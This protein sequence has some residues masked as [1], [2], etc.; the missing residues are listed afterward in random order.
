MAGSFKQLHLQIAGYVATVATASELPD[1]SGDSGHVGAVRWIEDTKRLVFWDG[2]AW[3]EQT[4]SNLVADNLTVNNIAYIN[5]NIVEVGDN[6]IL[7]NNDVTGAPSENSGLIVERGTSPDA[8]LQW[9]EATDTWQ[10]GLDG[11]PLYDFAPPDFSNVVAP[12]FLFTRNGAVAASTWLL[13]GDVPSNQASIH[14]AYSGL[15]VSKIYVDNSATNTFELGIYEHDHVTFTQLGTVTV[16][17]AYGDEF[18][19]AFPVT[20]GKKLAV[21][22]ESGSCNNVNVGVEL[23]TIP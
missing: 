10:A 5:A 12:N 21:K 11:G 1:L 22:V 13:S 23:H 19:V 14:I 18:T 4:F 20:I 7:L 9:N 8:I 17:A 15:Q 16:T 2:T 6:F 3:I